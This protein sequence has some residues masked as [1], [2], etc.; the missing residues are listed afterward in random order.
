MTPVTKIQAIVLVSSFAV[1]GGTIYLAAQTVDPSRSVPLAER[2]ADSSTSASSSVACIDPAGAVTWSKTG[3]CPSGT[4]QVPNACAA[5]WCVP[6]PPEGCPP[7]TV[8]AL[9][10][11]PQICGEGSECFPIVETTAECPPGSVLYEC[12]YGSSNVDGTETC[13]IP[14]GS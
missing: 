5:G 8:E 9:M 12:D 10:C 3:D 7:E 11:C 4:K 13:Y 14:P 2:S 6:C 1:L